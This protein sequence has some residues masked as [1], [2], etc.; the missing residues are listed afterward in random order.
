MCICSEAQCV[1]VIK[2]MVPKHGSPYVLP[3]AFTPTLLARTSGS[4]DPRTSG[5]LRLGSTG[6][7]YVAD[8]GSFNVV[9]KCY[10]TQTGRCGTDSEVPLK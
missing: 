4:L 8:A 2:T 7:G 6:L 5:D 9:A 1:L 3:E 10:E